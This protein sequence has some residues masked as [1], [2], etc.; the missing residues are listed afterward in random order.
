[1]KEEILYSKRATMD[2]DKT[3]LATSV[4][5]VPQCTMGHIWQPG[6]AWLPVSWRVSLL[7]EDGTGDAQ[8]QHPQD[9]ASALGEPLCQA[10]CEGTVLPSQSHAARAGLA[11]ASCKLGIPNCG[12][13][14]A[15]RRQAAVSPKMPT[16]GTGG[17][18][19]GSW[20][21]NQGHPCKHPDVCA[22]TC[23]FKVAL[24]QPRFVW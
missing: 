6:G 20:E 23:F 19:W 4:L 9:P 1:M 2:R 17:R 15:G 13:Q 12:V 22:D 16:P 24:V 18:A 21:G 11:T 7:G 14:V 5:D 3:L 10:G 8:W